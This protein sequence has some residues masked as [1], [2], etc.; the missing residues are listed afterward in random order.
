MTARATA[1]LSSHAAGLSHLTR[2]DLSPPL[3]A[4][5][6][7]RVG[8]RGPASRHGK[9]NQKRSDSGRRPFACRDSPARR[10]AHLTSL[11][12]AVGDSTASC[13][14]LS[15]S[16]WALAASSGSTAGSYSRRASAAKKVRL[17][18]EHQQAP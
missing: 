18:L 8:V 5:R 4:L 9:A 16:P 12:A 15:A 13:V 11:A 10:N 3:P 2:H 1:H 14:K 17:G 6:A 7:E